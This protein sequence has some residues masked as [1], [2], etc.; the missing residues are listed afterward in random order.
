MWFQ[1]I[2]SILLGIGLQIICVI[3]GKEF[4]CVLCFEYMIKVKL[5]INELSCFVRGILRQYN[6]Q[7]MEWLLFVLFI[8]IYREMEKE[9]KMR[10]KNM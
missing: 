10:Q 7:V 8:C 2:V 1:G 4:G 9:Q 6:I 3:F 5:K